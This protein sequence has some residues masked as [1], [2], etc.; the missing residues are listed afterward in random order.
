MKIGLPA[1]RREIWS[2]FV[3]LILET[4]GCGDKYHDYHELWQWTLAKKDC[5]RD[6]LQLSLLGSERPLSTGKTSVL[7]QAA[8]ATRPKHRSHK[9]IARSH[10]AFVLEI[11]AGCNEG[12]L[13]EGLE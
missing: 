7:A 13:E 2:G 4:I 5:Y 9:D 8:A 11:Q 6:P 10:G 3:R 1:N 12:S